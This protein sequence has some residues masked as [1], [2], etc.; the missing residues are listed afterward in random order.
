MLL[1]VQDDAKGKACTSALR[2]SS[3]SAAAIWFPPFRVMVAV[4]VTTSFV[5][6]VGD[7]VVGGTDGELEGDSV[8]GEADGAVVGV[9][10][11]GES[12]FGERV[13]GTD[14]ADVVGTVVVGVQSQMHS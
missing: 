8:I 3:L 2:T 14:G 6:I 13:G 12:V 7:V 10:V 5:K 4:I 1:M 9:V 11:V